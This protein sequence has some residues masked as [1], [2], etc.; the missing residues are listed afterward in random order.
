MLGVIALGDNGIETAMGVH[1]AN[2]LYVSL[3]YN[4]ADSGLPGLPSVVTAEASDPFAGLP[5]LIVAAID[6]DCHLVLEQE[7][8]SNSNIPLNVLDLN[9]HSSISSIFSM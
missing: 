2:N 4:S 8:G 3:L 5:F 6:N 1:I 9:F 7:R